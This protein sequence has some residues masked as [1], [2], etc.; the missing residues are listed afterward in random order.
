MKIRFISD[1]HA[2]L[3]QVYGPNFNDIMSEIQSADV[4][5]IAGDLSTCIPEAQDFLEKYFKDKKSDE[6]Y[7]LL[8][9]KLKEAKVLDANQNITIAI[10][11]Q[12]D[13]DYYNSAKAGQYDLI[14]STWGGA[15]INPVGLMQVYCDSTFESTC[16]YGFKGNQDKVMLE[17]DANGD[18]T[19]DPS[20]E[21]KSFNAWYLEANEIVENDE[22]G[23]PEWT[24]KH[25]RKLNI[26]AG[27]EAGILN[28]FEAIPLVARASSSLNSFK[29]ENGS[30][31]YINLIGYG[32]IRHMTFNYEDNSNIQVD[33]VDW[34]EN[35]I[36][37]ATGNSLDYNAITP[38]QHNV[39]CIIYGYRHGEWTLGH[40][41]EL[42]VLVNL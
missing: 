40:S 18:G 25:N 42:Q 37:R 28:R 8:D 35:G 12:K 16:E 32:G 33:H 22:Y 20:S 36:Y 13:E 19:I 17:I 14:F 11:S 6:Q 9:A 15:A 27:I 1:I 41:D 30:P 34:Y 26:L 38:G 23:S 31:T 29:I 24:T 21:N 5:L 2:T 4:T 10:D 3:N 7:I 39:R